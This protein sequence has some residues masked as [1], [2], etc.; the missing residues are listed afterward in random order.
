MNHSRRICRSLAGLPRRAG[1]L[2]AYAASA[3]LRADPPLPPGWNKHPPVPGS[4]PPP[5]RY[6]PGWN[7]HPPLPA[8]AHPLATSGTPGWQLALMAVTVILLAA[9]PVA[10]TYLGT[11]RAAAGARASPKRGPPTAPRRSAVAAPRRTTAPRQPAWPRWLRRAVHRGQTGSRQRGDW[12][13]PAS[14]A[15][16]VA[17]AAHGD[18]VT[19]VAAHRPAVYPLHPE[20]GRVLGQPHQRSGS[21]AAMVPVLLSVAGPKP[22]PRDPVRGPPRRNNPVNAH[23]AAL[24][25]LATAHTGSTAEVAAPNAP[26]PTPST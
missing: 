15:D 22:L 13:E 19:A 10:I 3:V 25:G 9:A 11:G 14:S 6:P 24:T 20:P 23:H 26:R 7:K 1:L 21:A 18:R 12:P 8:H 16:D 17:P 4:S 2:I 5:L